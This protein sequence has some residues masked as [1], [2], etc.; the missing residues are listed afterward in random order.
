MS[1]PVWR[2][3]DGLAGWLHKDKCK[4]CKPDPEYLN[5]NDGS[6]IIKC[7][8][9]KKNYEK[10]F[11][12]DLAKRFQNNWDS[13]MET[14]TNFIWCWGKVFIAMKTWIVDKGSM[15]YHCQVRKNSTAIWQWKTLQMLTS[16]T[17]GFEIS[18]YQT[19]DS[20]MIY[21]CKVMHYYPQMYLKSSAASAERYTMLILYFF[22]R[23]QD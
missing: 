6:F 11:D 8:V 3:A 10:E 1:S 13:V 23:H 2:L 5:A 18:E 16:N 21:T 15:K 14:L 19:Q 9:C 4:N 20:I 17:R 7:M 12:E 22:S